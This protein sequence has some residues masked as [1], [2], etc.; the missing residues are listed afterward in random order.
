MDFS[1]RDEELLAWIKSCPVRYIY[2]PR[3][4]TGS[5]LI[6]ACDEIYE[7]IPKV[8]VPVLILHGGDDAITS[9]DMSK[10][11]FDTC[12]S[13]DKECVIYDGSYHMLFLDRNREEVYM[14]CAEWMRERTGHKVFRESSYQL[15]SF[16]EKCER[17]R[18]DLMM[19]LES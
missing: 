8:L 14:K 15:M 6:T 1:T 13:K 17:S 19:N 9:N 3:A 2:G 5:S 16:S 18:K 10:E 12:I 4:I 11:L 7:S